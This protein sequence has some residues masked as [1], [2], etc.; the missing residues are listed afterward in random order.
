MPYISAENRPKFD[1]FLDL[2]HATREGM[3]IKS[4]GELNYVITQICLLYLNNSPLTYH[5]LCEIEGVLS[6]VSKELYSRVGEMY[7]A[8]KIDD[9]GDLPLM[10]HTLRKIRRGE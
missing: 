4:P 10:Q 5:K 9:N 2:L 6:H 7:E 8:M 1:R 3:L